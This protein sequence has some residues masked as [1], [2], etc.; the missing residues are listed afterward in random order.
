MAWIAVNKDGEE[1]IF[2]YKPTRQNDVWRDELTYNEPRTRYA[3]PNDYSILLPKGTIELII[4][5]K[6]TWADEPFL[7]HILLKRK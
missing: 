6:M 3:I 2:H 5:K 1:R 7:Y 4:G